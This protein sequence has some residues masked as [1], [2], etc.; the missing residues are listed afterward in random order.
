MG[1]LSELDFGE[2][3]PIMEKFL[4][5]HR[6]EE[7][8]KKDEKERLKKQAGE[9]V[10]VKDSTTG[11][12]VAKVVENDD[13]GGEAKK[14]EDGEGNDADEAKGGDGNNMEED[15]QTSE[16]EADTAKEPIA[17]ETK[18]ARDDDEG[19][20]NNDADEKEEPLTKKQKIDEG[21]D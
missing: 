10:K 19:A 16:K 12:F 9:E 13:G 6:K 18:H 5:G 8:N 21:G 20:E 3:V 15:K 11:Q 14:N 1:A 17:T 7:K 2:Y 4:E